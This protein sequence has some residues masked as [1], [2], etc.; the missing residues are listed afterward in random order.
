MRKKRARQPTLGSRLGAA[1]QALRGQQP[2][3]QGRDWWN[4]PAE[5]NDSSTPDSGVL[6]LRS[7]A[8]GDGRLAALSFLEWVAEV[9]SPAT[10]CIAKRQEQLSSLRFSFKAKDPDKAEAPEIEAQIARAKEYVTRRGGLGGP[11]VPWREFLLEA[12]WDALAIDALPIWVERDGAG[13]ITGHRMLSGLGVI[14]KRDANGWVPRPPEIAFEQW[15][16]GR[17]VQVNGRPGYTAEEL[18]YFRMRPRKKTVWGFPACEALVS[19]VMAWLFSEDWNLSFFTEGD[20][21]EGT[22]RTPDSWTVD[23]IIK[24]TQFVNTRPKLDPKARHKSSWTPAGP[25]FEPTRRRDDMEWDDLQM[26]AIHLTAALFG[27]NATTIGFAGQVY[28]ESQEDQIKAATRWGLVPTMLF[29]KDF[30]DLCLEDIGCGEI[31][32]DWLP[33]EEDRLKLSQLIRNAGPNVLTTNQ[34]RA[35]LGQDEVDSRLGNCLYMVTAT[36]L[37]VTYDPAAADPEAA[38]KITF[39]EKPLPAA[40]ASEEGMTDPEDAPE[41]EDIETPADASERAGADEPLDA[42]AQADLELWERKALRRLRQ[43]KGLGT[44]ASQAIPGATQSAIRRSLRAA[45]TPDDVR[46]AFRGAQEWRSRGESALNQLTDMAEMVLCQAGRHE[47]F[48][49]GNGQED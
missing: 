44:F 36:G 37:L 41:Q 10:I 46:R 42:A 39:S 47:T 21:T 29:I 35:L 34:A 43:G 38:Y 24:F 32:Q 7:E 17:R 22:W 18:Y 5:N 27:F 16:N 20:T 45:T 40:E 23:Q 28:K 19:Q 11:G 3:N 26:R 14:P 4:A 30:I 49:G 48:L 33:E 9:Y 13:N 6:G 25:Q 31:E 2:H 1:W 8:T 15:I 12:I